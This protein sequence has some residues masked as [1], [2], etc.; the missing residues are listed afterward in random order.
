MRGWQDAVLTRGRQ[1]WS[2]A[3]D[4]LFPPRCGGC[5]TAGS[6]WCAAC[7]QSLAFILPPMC[8]ACGEP[9]TTGLCAKCRAQPLRI[10]WIR[11]AVVFQ[12]PVREAIHHFK[13]NRWSSL[14][15]PLGE[16]LTAAWMAAAPAAD[17]LVPVPLHRARER[18]RG[19]NQSALLAAELGRRVNVHVAPR[20]LRRVRATRVQMQL[21]AAERRI[22]VAGAFAADGEW[23]GRRVVVIDDVCTTGATLEACAAALY[24]AGAAAVYGLTL[25]RTP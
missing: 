13:Y 6:L 24:S 19:Y 4:T 3:I 17:W 7:R 9:A 15:G 11:S 25:A 10:E 8:D 22:N 5:G 1:A 21:D 14:A 12:G 18:E 2:V 16:A 23:S 20:G